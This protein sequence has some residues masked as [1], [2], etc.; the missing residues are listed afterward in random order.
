MW[1]RGG[2]TD[3]CVLLTLDR[4]GS[5]QIEV[6]IPKGGCIAAALSDECL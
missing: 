3:L 1:K 4:R 6:V 2:G 5:I